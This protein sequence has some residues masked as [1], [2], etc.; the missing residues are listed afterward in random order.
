MPTH[1]INYYK[2]ARITLSEAYALSALGTRLRDKLT[3]AVHR[4]ALRVCAS[5]HLSTPRPILVKLNINNYRFRL[6]LSSLADYYVLHEVFLNNEYALTQNITPR[7]I[8][9]LGANIGCSAIF[10]HTK[11]PDAIIYAIEAAPNTFVRLKANVASFPNIVPIHAAIATTDGTALFSCN[12]THT[13]ASLATE[14]ATSSTN[15]PAITLT[16]LRERYN[17]SIIDLLKFDIEGAEYEVF[18]CAPQKYIRT[19]IGE[20]HPDITQ[21]SIE[22]FLHIFPHHTAKCSPRRGGRAVIELYGDVLE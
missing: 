13:Q 9:D 15:V 10:F 7:V 5:L 8:I 21:R 18:R 16:T 17:I 4:I 6:T 1:L 22:D 2:F 20:V 14:D 19:L 11:Y 3:I 12:Q